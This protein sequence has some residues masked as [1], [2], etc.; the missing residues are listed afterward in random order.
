MTSFYVHFLK[1]DLNEPSGSCVP[2]GI[3]F[4]CGV[5]SKRRFPWVVDWLAV[6]SCLGQPV[7]LL[8]C[9]MDGKS[10]GWSLK[11]EKGFTAKLNKRLNGK[12]MKMN[13]RKKS[14]MRVVRWLEWN[15]YPM[16]FWSWSAKSVLEFTR[17]IL[18]S[19]PEILKPLWKVLIY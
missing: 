3:P 4:V 13:Y 2:L 14:E 17:L 6:A 15:C 5:C 12:K 19:C 18:C 10:C 1:P 11:F 9:R 8:C 7:T 16:F